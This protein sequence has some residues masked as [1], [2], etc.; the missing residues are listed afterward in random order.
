MECACADSPSCSILRMKSAS[1]ERGRPVRRPRP[2]TVAVRAE[3]PPG[4]RL[5]ALALVREWYLAAPPLWIEFPK[6]EIHCTDS[7]SVK[8]LLHLNR[9][10][11]KKLEY[12][13]VEV[14]ARWLRR[15]RARAVVE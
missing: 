14:D 10:T 4:C 2:D 5:T 6:F 3:P 11:G 13:P 15:S 9:F 8:Q 12:L 7:K 1:I